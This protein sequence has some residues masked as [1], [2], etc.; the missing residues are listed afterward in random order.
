MEPKIDTFGL[1]VSDVARLLRGAFERKIDSAGL[2][3]TPAEARTLIHVAAA[4]GSRQLD[5][6]GRMGVEPMT[7]CACLDRL[8]ASG[9]V[10]RVQDTRD[11]RAKKVTITPAG[12]A[13]LGRIRTELRDLDGSM[14]AGLEEETLDVLRHALQ[15]MRENLHQSHAIAAAGRDRAGT[16][17]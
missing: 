12:D 7:V 11:R 2:G 17:A 5:L 4:D 3:V 8:Q 13:L 10:A 6:A 15:R 9:L 14:V 16:A 1:L